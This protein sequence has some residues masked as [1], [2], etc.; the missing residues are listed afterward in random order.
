M[1]PWQF[2]FAAVVVCF[3]ATAQMV[4]GFGFALLAVPMMGI[5][6]DLKTAVVVCTICGTSSNTYQAIVDKGHRDGRL[7]IRLILA[8]MA[9]MPLGWFLIERATS[10]QL[11]VVVG[12]VVLLAIVALSQLRVAL[13]RLSVFDWIAGV[14]S[15]AL[16]IATSTNGPPLVILLRAKRLSPNEFRSTINSIFS[17]I[18]MVSIAV[19]AVG[20]RVTTDVM[21]ATAL[22]IPGLVVGIAVGRRIRSR[23]SDSIFWRLVLML[24]VATAVASIVTGVF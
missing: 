10:D 9:G 24:L 23:L 6:V 15:G 11:K 17:V 3:A 14:V 4:S 2:V 21:I 18:A 20:G 16:A 19:F 22:S 12:C 1:S 5:V 7:A 13:P 8:S